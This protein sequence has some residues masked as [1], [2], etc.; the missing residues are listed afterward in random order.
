MAQQAAGRQ[1]AHQSHAA[2]ATLVVGLFVVALALAG[3][4]VWNVALASPALASA[5]PLAPDGVHVNGPDGAP[6]TIVRF[7]DFQCAECATFAREIQPLL[8]SEFVEAGVAR[9]ILRHYPVLGYESSRAAE[10]AECAASQGKFWKY[11]ALL[12]GWQG[13]P[14]SGY[15]SDELLVQLAQGI[16]MSTRELATCL[17]SGA[18][19]EIVARD[20]SDGI[21]LGLTSPLGVYVNG[22]L[23]DD[24]LDHRQLRLHIISAAAGN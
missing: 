3:F 24:P 16:R 13:R 5:D 21:S 18:A 8:E 12:H 10:A 9:L 4:I 14:N 22:K 2:A 7:T 11:A 23:V 1:Q 19:Q 6:V 15:F 17:A 20:L